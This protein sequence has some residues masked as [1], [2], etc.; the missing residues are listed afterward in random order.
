[1]RYCKLVLL[2][3]GTMIFMSVEINKDLRVLNAYLCHKSVSLNV[4]QYM[5][6]SKISENLDTSSKSNGISLEMLHC[7]NT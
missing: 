7:S 1:M 3:D 5:I 2:V 6:I 4:N